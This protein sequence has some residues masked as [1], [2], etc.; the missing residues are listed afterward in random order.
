MNHVVIMSGGS[1][2]RFWP[3]SRRDRPK[4]LLPLADERPILRAT[5]ERVLPLIPPERVWVVTT[6]ITAAATRHL[7]HE[8]DA[9]HVLIEPEGRDTAAC[10]GYAAHVLLQSDRDAVC[11]VLPADHIIGAEDRFRSA[12]AAGMETV[13][14]TGG[15]LTFGVRPTH[16]E[17]G[18]GYLKIGPRQQIVDGWP[19][20]RLER[21]VEKPDPATARSYVDGAEHLWNSGIFVWRAGELLDELGR[22]L[23]ELAAGLGRVA[24]ALGTPAAADVLA[25]VYPQL[26]RISV[27]YG[28]MEGAARCWTIPVDFPWS[29]IGAWPALADLLEADRQGNTGRGRTVFVSSRSNVVISDGPV[30]AVAGVEDLIVVATPD[31]VLVVPRDQAQRV[32]EIV[33]ELERQ[34]WDDVL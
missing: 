29:D 4:Q 11:A 1:G 14:Q 26:P 18:Y 20:H 24:A 9:D 33:A 3:A 2:T 19:V 28:V 8:L 34:G 32:K 27:D 12:L 30:V 23:P 22:Q 17:T 10:A 31:A 5:Y 15:L 13:A 6:N 16:P 25:T 21:F 7:L